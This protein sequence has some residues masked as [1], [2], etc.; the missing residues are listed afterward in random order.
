MTF[1]FQTALTH[2]RCVGSCYRHG[3]ISLVQCDADPPPPTNYF[4]TTL[5]EVS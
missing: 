3:E 5:G 1:H 4:L 2:L